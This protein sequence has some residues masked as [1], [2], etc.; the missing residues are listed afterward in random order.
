MR[1]LILVYNS[2][3][4]HYVAV[5]SEVIEQV[6]KIPGWMVGKF[7]V[8]KTAVDENAELLAQMLRDGDLVVSAGGDGTAAVA[9][10]GVMLAGKNV[11][12]GV[13]GYGNFNDMAG[14]LG[15]KR[16]VE[17]GDEYLG[18]VREIVEKFERDELKEIYPLEVIVDG[19]HWRWAACYVTMGL[20]AE[21]TQAMN[22]KR[23]RKKLKTGKQGVGF[24]LFVAL[25]WFLRNRRRQFLPEE[26]KM[27]GKMAPSRTTDYLAVNGPRLAKVMKG[28][29]WYLDA[30]KFGS[31]TR[32]LSG[33]WRMVGF[34]LRSVV[35]GIKLSDSEGDAIEFGEPT[36]VVVQAEGESEKM[37]ILRM[38][39][40]KGSRIKVVCGDGKDAS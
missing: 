16:P 9:L 25:K 19:K 13:L 6:W 40:R 4:S 8:K 24:S 28:G 35:F 14:M 15:V 30:E 3:A 5:R 38:E 12:L 36:E 29:K 27:N 22:E 32:R 21:A 2:G 17:Y 20:L 37:K 7:E 23:V 11:A 1:K 31:V 26:I 33:F 39:A 34:G 10:N 18:G